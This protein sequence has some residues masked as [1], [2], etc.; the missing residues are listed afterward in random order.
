MWVSCRRATE[1]L[2]MKME[3]PL[4]WHESISLRLH[5]RICDGCRR[6]ET[7][8]KFLRQASQEWA[9]RNSK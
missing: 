5:L 9:R 4:R 8:M 1:L 3:Q 2:S 7:Q 6:A